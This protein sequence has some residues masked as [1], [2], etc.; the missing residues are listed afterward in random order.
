M[1]HLTDVSNFASKNS[2]NTK[3]TNRIST[4][5]LLAFGTAVSI[6]GQTDK[7]LAPEDTAF[8]SHTLQY[9]TIKARQ[10]D[11]SRLRVAKTEI[12]GAGELEA[13]NATTIPAI[14]P[15]QAVTT[16]YDPR[17]STYQDI[18]KAFEKIGYRIEAVGKEK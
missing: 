16:I 9:V 7:T 18:E 5:L 1:V 8:H 4:S 13:A 11:R 12:I 3:K 6:C 14:V 10:S 2:P 15:Q 17:K